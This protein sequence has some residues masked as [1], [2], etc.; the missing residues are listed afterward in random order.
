MSLQIETENLIIR[1]LREEDAADLLEHIVEPASRKH[2][3]FQHSERFYSK[4]IFESAIAW[5]NYPKQREYYELAVLLKTDNSLIGTCS[6]YGV[7]PKSIET[8]IG[9]HYK[10]EY[11][12]N[13]YATEAAQQ[14]LHIGFEI[15]KVELI[16]ADCFADN[17]ASIRILEKIGMKQNRDFPSIDKLNGYGESKPTLRHQ[18]W[19]K[20]WLNP[21]E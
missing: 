16:F 20:E 5:A 4:Q 9:W 12:G 14:L 21:T 18:I 17:F 13:G 19:R 7:I 8:S 6:L 11:Q 10:S 15:N 1:D 3:L 2:I